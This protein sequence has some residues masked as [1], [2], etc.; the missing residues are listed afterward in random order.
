MH[1]NTIL[2]VII[3]ALGG[4]IAGFLLA[5]SINRSQLIVAR[6]Q[7]PS[8]SAPAANTSADSQGTELTASEIRAKIVEAD[9]KPN[10][11]DYQKNLGGALYKY[12]AMKQDAA[13]LVESARILERAN[14]L[15]AGDI[16]VLVALGNAKFDIAYADKNNAGFASAREIYAKALELKPGDADIST[17]RALTYF[18]LEPPDYDKARTELQ[19]IADANPKHERSLQFLVKALVNEKKIAEA[20]KALARLKEI[21]PQNRSMSELQDEITQARAGNK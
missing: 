11:F 15:K 6:D 5:N 20:D 18:F 8:S 3:A 16:D 2:F 4:F 1:K 14:S 7:G 19:K 21:N 17:D 13:L 10:D 12:A 9:K